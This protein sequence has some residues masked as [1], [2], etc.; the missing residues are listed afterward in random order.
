[1]LACVFLDSH[2]LLRTR[3]SPLWIFGKE[4][5]GD[6]CHGMP[7][8]MPTWYG[9]KSVSQF[10]TRMIVFVRCEERSHP[11]ARSQRPDAG[12]LHSWRMCATCKIR[13]Q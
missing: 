2:R 11:H 5:G 3:H 7:D 6:D 9:E 4:D 1:M 13:A 8:S 10:G 12:L